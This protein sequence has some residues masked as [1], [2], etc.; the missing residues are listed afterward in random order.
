MVPEGD[1]L[2]MDDELA[3]LP[4]LAAGHIKVER[5]SAGCA[6]VTLNRPAQKNAMTLAMWQGLAL[7]FEA[8]GR[9]AALRT[10]ILTGAGGSFCAGAD[11][12]EFATVRASAQDIET[13]AHWVDRCTLAIVDCPKATFAAVSGYAYGGGCGL[14][15]SCDFRI[16][17]RTAKFA[18]PAAKLSIVYGIEETR[19]LYQAV[20]LTAAKEMLFSAAPHDAE[21]AR[22]IGLVSEVTEGDVMAAAHRRSDALAASAP[23]TIA[24]AKLVL[25]AL[26]KGETAER[27]ERAEAA[28]RH[29]GA[30]ADYAEGRTAFVEKRAPRFTGR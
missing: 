30:S 8:L 11:I 28:A 27:V 4:A 23:L 16:A 6:V 19:A 15:V 2:T 14:A 17:D 13:Y 12:K 9:E 25:E 5:P 10:V 20:G 24:G 29:A 1:E 3:A 18:I 7:T 26:T 21:A 22:A